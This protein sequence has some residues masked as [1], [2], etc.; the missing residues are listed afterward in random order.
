MKMLIFVALLLCAPLASYAAMSQADCPPDTIWN[1]STNQCYPD[2]N[3]PSAIKARKEEEK[4]RL[5]AE[6]LKEEQRLKQ[7]MEEA[8]GE[9]NKIMK[10]QMY[11]SPLNPTNR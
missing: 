1:S 8:G 11:P 2:P 6:R 3:A 5:E 7:E 4:A 9:S 10:K